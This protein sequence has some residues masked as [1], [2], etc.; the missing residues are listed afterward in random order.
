M[1]KIALKIFTS[2]SRKLS[3]QATNFITVMQ[4]CRDK[5]LKLSTDS[6]FKYKI[7]QCN[8]DGY[9]SPGVTVCAKQNY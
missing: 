3:W 7:H 8:L 1:D 5:N 6:V 4:D 9:A 2:N